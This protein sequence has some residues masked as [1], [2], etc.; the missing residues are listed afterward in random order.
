MSRSFFLPHLGVER[1]EELGYLQP[2][3]RGRTLK[4][5]KG[6]G[7]QKGIPQNGTHSTHVKVHYN[8]LCFDTEMEAISVSSTRGIVNYDT[9]TLETPRGQ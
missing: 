2:G 3:E 4:T 5:A 9:F 6:T 8:N 7:F 1:T